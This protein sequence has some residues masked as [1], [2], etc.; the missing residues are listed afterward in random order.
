[1]TLKVIDM[2]PGSGK[3]TLMCR[4]LAGLDNN[5]RF[6]YIT[7]YVDEVDKIEQQIFEDGL[8]ELQHDAYVYRLRLRHSGS[9][10]RKVNIG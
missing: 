1:M 6:I 9:L 3:T 10:C 2:L 4:Y 5:E 7:P 8:N